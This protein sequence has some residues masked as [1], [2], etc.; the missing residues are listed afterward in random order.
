MRVVFEANGMPPQK[1]PT[2]GSPVRVLA[3]LPP[4][5][6]PVLIVLRFTALCV[7]AQL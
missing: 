5:A 6:H 7:R 2:P 1:D 3:D 4:G